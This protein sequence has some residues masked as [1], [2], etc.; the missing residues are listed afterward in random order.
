MDFIDETFANLSSLAKHHLPAGEFTNLISEGLIPG[1]GWNCNFHSTNCLLFLFISIL[2]KRL[3]ESRSVLM[4]KIMRKF[5]L[6]G[7]SIVPLISGT[8]CCYSSHYEC[9]KYRKLERTINYDFSHAF[10]HLFGEITS[11]C[12]FNF[13][14]Y[15]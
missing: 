4:D 15:S 8:A 11:L 6:S 3:H 9:K 10:H 12:D 13:L 1:I 7:K 14:N 2:E 5:G